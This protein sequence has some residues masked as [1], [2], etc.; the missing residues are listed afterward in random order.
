MARARSGQQASLLVNIMNRVTETASPDSSRWDD[1]WSRADGEARARDLFA[2]TFGSTPHAVWSAP[3]RINLVGDH[4]DY[5]AGLCLPAIIRHR[6]Y[7][8]GRTRDPTASCASSG[9]TA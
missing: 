2:H 8:A 5:N 7:V 3:G 6:A 1:P 9:P 4:T